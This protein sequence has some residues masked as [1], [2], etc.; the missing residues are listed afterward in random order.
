MPCFTRR[1]LTALFIASSLGF[2]PGLLSAADKT[3]TVTRQTLSEFGEALYPSDFTHFPYVNP[4]APKG[5]SVV[6]GSIGT[7]DTLNTY[8]AK[9]EWPSSIGL[10]SDSL[11][12]A[13]SDEL[14]GLYG[15]IAESVE[16]PKDLSWAI[17][18]L[19]EGVKYHDGKPVVAGDFVY[20]LNMIKTHARVFIQAA[21]EDIESAEALDAK[22]VKFTFR[23]KDSM[24]PMVTAAGIS[25]LPEHYWSDKDISQPTLEPPLSSGAYKITKLEAGKSISFERVE[26]YWGKDLAFNKGKNNFDKI[27]Y[28]YYLDMTVMFEAFKGGEIDFWSESDP[29]RWSKEFDFSAIESGEIIKVAEKNEAPQGLNGFMFNVG[30]DKFDDLNVRKAITYMY[31]F[32]TTQR[33]LLHGFFE[34]SNSYFPNSDYASS[35]LPSEEELLLLNP[36]KDQLPAA[37]FTETFKLP[38]T[39]GSGRDRKNKRTA[40]KLFKE[41]GWITK[42]GKL[43]HAETQEQFSIE[44]VTGWPDNERIVAPF[45]KRLQGIGIDAQIRVVDSAQ[46]RSKIRDGDFDAFMASYTFYPPPGRELRGYWHSSTAD[47]RSGNST[48]IKNPVVDHLIDYVLDQTNEEKMK[49]GMRALDRVMLWN[50][51]SLPRYYRDESWF[52]Y[53]KTIQ[54]PEIRGKYSVGFPSTWWKA[55]N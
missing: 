25:P 23:T 44:I 9:G 45:I 41:S 16:Y 21:Y 1:T 19:R 6:V 7:F 27:R 42:G 20:A 4:Q 5:G 40:L 33:Q 22:R 14:D 31:D 15:V 38:K 12:S 28:D 24:K 2:H 32:E 8:V 13:S 26:D 51:Y 37:L 48:K 30:L 54:R 17:F 35:D 53:S 3:E 39:D 36:F 11:M 10:T 47:D 50:Y 46:W 43:I 52:A 49:V 55:E 34:R 29:K 18:T